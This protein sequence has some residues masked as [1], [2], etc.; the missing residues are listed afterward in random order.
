MVYMDKDYSELIE[1]LDKRFT[2]IDE[3]LKDLKENKADKK[4]VQDLMNSIDRLA[5]A[6]EIYHDEQKAISA[7]IDIHEKWIHQIA[8]KLGIK[9]S[10]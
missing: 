10:Y 9:L 2:N 5:K 6:I 4:D 3:D 8:E 1:Y 7:K